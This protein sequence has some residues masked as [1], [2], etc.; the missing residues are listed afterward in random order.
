MAFFFEWGRIF[1]GAL[2]LILMHTGKSKE[3][4]GLKIFF[5]NIFAVPLNVKT[6]NPL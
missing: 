1:M 6:E 2:R 5:Q 4:R 3:G